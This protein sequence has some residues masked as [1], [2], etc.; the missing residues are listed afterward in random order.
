MEHQEPKMYAPE[1]KY[2]EESEIKKKKIIIAWSH[3]DRHHGGHE[4]GSLW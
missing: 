3:R 4:T 1:T 2:E